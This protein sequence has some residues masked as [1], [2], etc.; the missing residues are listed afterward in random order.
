MNNRTKDKFLIGLVL[1]LVLANI[2]SISMFWLGKPNQK[3]DRQKGT[4]SA[5]LINELKFDKKQQEQLE[6]FRQEHKQAAEPLREQ[7]A[8]SKNLFFK[9]LEQ[10]ALADTQIINA[11][12]AVTAI[13]Q[14]LDLLAFD[15]FKKVRKICTEIQ[16]EKFDK[17]IGQV[18]HII[19]NPRN[20]PPPGDNRP[21]PNEGDENKPPNNEQDEKPAQPR[22][23]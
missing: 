15:H 16:K 18:A 2:T 11:E 17:I 19:G 10:P 3:P 6:I 1:L 20:P 7:L 22:N 9:L 12:N 21:P 13:T 8:M 14:K 4:P 5:F 23:N